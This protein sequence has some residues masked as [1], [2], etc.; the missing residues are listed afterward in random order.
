MAG[1][2]GKTPSIKD[3]AVLAKVSVPTVSRYL[4]TPQRVSE[5]RAQAIAEAIAMLGYRPNPIARALVRKRTRSIAVLTTNTALYGQSQ[6]LRG[7]EQAASDAGYALDIVVLAGNT[8]QSLHNIVQT[9]L[10]RNPAGVILLNFDSV[11]KKSFDYLPNTLPVV[12]IAG[13]RVPDTAQISLSEREGG[14]AITRHLLSLGH[15]KVHHVTIPGGVGSYSRLSGWREACEEASMPIPPAIESSWE[16]EDARAIGR[17]LGVDSEVTAI[18]AGNDEL[19]MGII[20]GLAD[21]GKRVPED[22]SVAGFDDH[23]I[24]RIWNPSLTTV[25]QH[26]QEVGVR[27]FEMLHAKM[28]DLAKDLGHTENWNKLVTVPGELIIRDSTGP[29]RA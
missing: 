1:S 22:V 5:E 19:A 11:S 27:S 3:V 25:H 12:M 24:G 14:Y 29:V 2:A 9:C 13:D 16:P 28:D 26:F 8:N 20:R 17:R 6:T 10:D 4:N 18:F 23:P 21:A 7:V 15:R